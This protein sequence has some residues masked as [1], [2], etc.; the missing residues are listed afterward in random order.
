MEIIVINGY[1]ESEIQ[2][3]KHKLFHVRNSEAMKFI[4]DLDLCLENKVITKTHISNILNKESTLKSFDFYK[5][6]L[7]A[8][9]LECRKKPDDKPTTT[10]AP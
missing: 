2:F 9:E 3:G 7:N 10:I 1:E 6:Q 4:S 5:D 8:L